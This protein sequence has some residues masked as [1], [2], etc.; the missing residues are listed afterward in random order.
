MAISARSG[1]LRTLTAYR[2]N[3]AWS[4]AYLNNLINDE[5]YDRRDAALVTNIVYGVLQNAAL[6]DFYI[7]C[8]SKTPPSKMHPMVLDILRLS[9][10]QLVFMDKIPASAAVNESVV[11]MTA[12]RLKRAFAV[13]KSAYDCKR[14]VK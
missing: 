13:N 8:Y 6:C 9:V 12:V 3:G 10:Y 4:D 14:R 11:Q 2:K 7:S 5:G 1:V